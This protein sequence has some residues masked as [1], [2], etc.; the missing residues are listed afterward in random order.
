[1]T[2]KSP[3]PPFREL[4]DAGRWLQDGET[5]IETHGP[6]FR[7]SMR[8]PGGE[9]RFCEWKAPRGAVASFKGMVHIVAQC[10]YDLRRHDFE[11]T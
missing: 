8:T 4:E 5:L 7:A 11:I 6:W 10:F 9:V 3:T 2:S 1:M